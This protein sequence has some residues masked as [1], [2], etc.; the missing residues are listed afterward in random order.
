MS[1]ADADRVSDGMFAGIAR[2]YRPCAL[3]APYRVAARRHPG[4]VGRHSASPGH[5]EHDP[6][7]IWRSQLA[8]AKEA[9][10]KTGLAASDIAASDFP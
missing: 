5:V 2:R 7:A 9:L 6:E 3:L 4:S 10:E 1:A 8:V